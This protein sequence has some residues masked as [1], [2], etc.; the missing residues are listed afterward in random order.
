MTPQAALATESDHHAA[1]HRPRPTAQAALT[2]ATLLALIA[3]CGSPAQPGAAGAS[4][5]PSFAGP[6]PTVSS[7]PQHGSDRPGAEQ[8]A[9]STASPPAAALNAAYR[10]AAAWVRG[11]LPRAQWYAGVEPLCSPAFAARLRTVDPGNVPASRVT[12]TARTSSSH[13]NTVVTAV[14]TNGG[15]LSVTVTRY[16]GRWLVSNNAFNRAVTP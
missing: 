3:A 14:P 1:K 15:V 7:S 5:V 9:R 6:I 13:P 11:D 12:G 16:N 4:T 10:F 8:P 2:L